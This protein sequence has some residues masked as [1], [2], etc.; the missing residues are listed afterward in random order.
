[1]C[2]D[3]SVTKDVSACGAPYGWAKGGYATGICIVTNCGISNS[4]SV[5]VGPSAGSSIAGRAARG[6]GNYSCSMRSELV[7][8]P[9]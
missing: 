7:Y 5:V 4:A 2:M 3:A 6:A 8:A 1:M 9:S